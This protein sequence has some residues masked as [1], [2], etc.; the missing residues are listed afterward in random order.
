MV[1]FSRVLPLQSLADNL[2]L[3]CLEVEK[4][5]LSSGRQVRILDKSAEFHKSFAFYFLLLSLEVCSRTDERIAWKS[6]QRGKKGSMERRGDFNSYPG[7][8]SLQL[9]TVSSEN[10]VLNK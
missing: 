6:C 1:P 9:F 8:S 10:T 7:T 5:V 4:Q 2:D 3:I